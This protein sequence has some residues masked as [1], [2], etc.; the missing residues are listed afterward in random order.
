M[1]LAET[2]ASAFEEALARAPVLGAG[3]L[4]DPPRPSYIFANLNDPLVK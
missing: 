2:S 4:Q 3:A 1:P